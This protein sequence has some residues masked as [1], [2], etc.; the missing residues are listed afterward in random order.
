MQ[1]LL[2]YSNKLNCCD[3]LGQ[4]NVSAD[5]T[6]LRTGFIRCD[7]GGKKDYRDVA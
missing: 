1:S 2:Y 6:R 7:K 3:R 5:I 4:K